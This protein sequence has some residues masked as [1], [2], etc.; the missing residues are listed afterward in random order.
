MFLNV[1]PSRPSSAGAVADR[2]AN[3]IFWAPKRKVHL[4]CVETEALTVFVRAGDK[5]A[6]NH[7]LEAFYNQ[8]AGPPISVPRYLWQ[9]KNDSERE[10]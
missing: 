3:G 10:G 1:F 7:F 9:R 4:E 8:E 2:L 6:V 5:R